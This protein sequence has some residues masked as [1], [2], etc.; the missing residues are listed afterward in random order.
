M[1]SESVRNID[2]IVGE[3]DSRGVSLFT[4]CFDN[5]KP[6]SYHLLFRPTDEQHITLESNTER[7]SEDMD[8]FIPITE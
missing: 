7:K 5:M 6:F 4:D 1:L 2:K 8:L 3:V